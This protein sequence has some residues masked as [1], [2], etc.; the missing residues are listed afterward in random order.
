MGVEGGKVLTN[1]ND[2]QIEIVSTIL[3]PDYWRA[4]FQRKVADLELVKEV[5]K[6]GKI[7]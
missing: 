2:E 5:I 3:D 7:P 6:E 1:L 4:T